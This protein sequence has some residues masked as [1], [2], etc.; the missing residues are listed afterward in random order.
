[1]FAFLFS[2]IYQAFFLVYLKKSRN[3][4]VLLMQKEKNKTTLVSNLVFFKAIHL[5]TE[6]NKVNLNN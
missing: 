3:F 4:L 1:M 6:T 2:A 5:G